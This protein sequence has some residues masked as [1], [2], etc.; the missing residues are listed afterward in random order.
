M[1][2]TISAPDAAIQPTVGRGDRQPHEV[3]WSLTNAWV[4][5]RCLQLIAAIGVADRIADEPVSV[6]AL[7]GT[8]H[9]D[10]DALDRM[11]S[12]LASHGIFARTSHGYAHTATSR[13]LRKDDPASMWAFPTM[14]GLPL[15][16]TAYAK[17]EHCL[18]TG[19]PATETVEPA[20]LWAYLADR[21]D[22]AQVFA[23]AMQARAAGD[24]GAVRASYDFSRFETIADIGGGRGHL[25]R[26][27]LEDALSARGILFDLPDVIHTLGAAGE[28]L[29][30]HAGDFF[31]DPLPAADA[32]LVMEILHDW[33]DPDCTRI[34]S[35]IRRA[36]APGAKLLVI[37]EVI[38]ARGQ[39]PGGHNLDVIMLAVTGG[40]ERTAPELDD[41]FAQAGF[42]AGTVIETGGRV[43][44][45]ETTAV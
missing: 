39:D 9:V 31:A 21:P 5:S 22:E 29:S 41:L 40:R 8:L 37:E 19:A 20:G 3:L 26:A 35:A 17:L 12:L 30:L 44:I 42:S 15:S 7:A 34:L 14:N 32:Y 6:D 24:I 27:I 45:V 10:P 23:Q 11:L 28:R 33:D 13:L 1:S 18:R 25:L 16:T 2:T 38:T 43:R 4:T 36:A